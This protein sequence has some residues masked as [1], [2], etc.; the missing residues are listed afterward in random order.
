LSRLSIAAGHAHAWLYD[1]SDGRVGARIGGHPVLLLT[2]TGRR[3]GRPRR[4]PVQYERIDGEIVL[5]AA[6]GGAPEDPAWFRNLLAE[7]QVRVRI[8]RR[9]GPA[10]ASVAAEEQ[11]SRL[12]P[13]LCARNPALSRVARRAHRAIPLVILRTGEWA[14]FG[15]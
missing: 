13:E 5:V 6:A 1:R 15:P 10:V 9:E 2:T 8:G 11:R 7:P 4:T 12:W 3:S 14:P